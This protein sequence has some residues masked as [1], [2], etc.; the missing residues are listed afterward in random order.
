MSAIILQGYDGGNLV[1]QGYDDSSPGVSTLIV[2]DGTAKPD[3]ESFCSVAYADDYFTR[4]G[5]T[6]W[7]D[8]ALFDKEV[9]LRL[10]TDYIEQ[11]Y[12]LRWMGYK[13]TVA[14]ALSWPRWE[15]YNLDVAYGYYGWANYVG[16]NTVPD[17]VIRG[18]AELALKSRSGPLTVDGDRLKHRVR[19]G[20][21]NGVDITYDPNQQLNKVYLAVEGWFAPFLR[22]YS[23][24][25]QAH[26][27][28]LVRA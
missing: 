10:A 15:V 6:A 16:Y 21:N 14:Q 4:R 2:E 11:E 18:T 25:G 9:A 8:L 20:G 1:L 19:I 23:K 7:T 27:I 22:D 13:F 26:S 3:A 28:S 17:L 24:P 5:I 12:R